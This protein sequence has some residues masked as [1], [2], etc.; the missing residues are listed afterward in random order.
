[1]AD[2]KKTS[3]LGRLPFTITIHKIIDRKGGVLGPGQLVASSH[4]LEGAVKRA[5]SCRGLGGDI[6]SGPSSAARIVDQRTGEDHG[7]WFL[8]TRHSVRGKTATL[9]L[10]LVKHEGGPLTVQDVLPKSAEVV[11]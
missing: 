3:R 2:S 4:T 5:R 8:T 11:S 6:F 1:M 9:S 7:W 10:V